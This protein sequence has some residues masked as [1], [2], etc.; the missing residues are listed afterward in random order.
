MDTMM[1]KPII[2]SVI[3]H[4]AII[5]GL[6]IV[7]L[8][9]SW[10]QGVSDQTISLDLSS[11]PQVQKVT[12]PPVVKHE[13]ADKVVKKIEEN[14]TPVQAD[15]E[16]KLAGGYQVI[17]QYPEGLRRRGIEGTVL[18]NIEILPN[19]SVG[20]I[21]VLQSAG[22]ASFDNSAIEAV[23]QWHFNSAI[24]SGIPVS[25]WIK[26]PVKFTLQ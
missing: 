9:A 25:S 14:P 15:T 5:A 8:F 22:Y 17:P 23:R 12:T 6:Y 20:E 3:I 18:L 7:F 26:L 1:K 4:A 13:L 16:A 21:R 19:G 2:I 11:S 10:P 24:K